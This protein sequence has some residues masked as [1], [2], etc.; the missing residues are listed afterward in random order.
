MIAPERF[1]PEPRRIERVRH[2]TKRRTVRTRRR[3]H[4]PVHAVVTLVMLLLLPLLGWVALT[5]S[6]TS[7]TFALIHAEQERTA[8]VDETQRLEDRVARLQ[9]PERLAALAAA[10]HLHDPHV[11]AVVRIPEPKAQPR[12]TGLAFF[13]TLFTGS[14]R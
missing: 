2:A 4:R 12:P 10:L 6:L 8:L 11:Y 3:L 5:S 13:G 14:S 7:K 9:S 1:A